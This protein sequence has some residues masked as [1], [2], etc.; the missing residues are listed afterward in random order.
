MKR[1]EFIVYG[2]DR[3]FEFM[4]QHGAQ[5]W[6]C[7]AQPRK[8]DGQR[9]APIAARFGMRYAFADSKVLDGFERLS[10]RL[11]CVGKHR[12][13]LQTRESPARQGSRVVLVDDLAATQIDP[14]RAW[15]S[16][17]LAI[18]ETSPENFQALLVASR[19]LSRDEHFRAARFLAARFDGDPGAAAVDQLHR[20]PG[21]PNFKSAALVN[22]KPFVCRLVGLFEAEE[23]FDLEATLNEAL[24]A[25]A[26]PAR[27]APR[28]RPA[29][30]NAPDADNSAAAFGWTLRQVQLGVRYEA[31]LTELRAS[32]L[33]HHDPH[34]WPARTLHNALHVLGMRSSR[35][36][37]LRDKRP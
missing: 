24:G 15:W 18:L 1:E 12:V 33:G 17:P 10:A 34:D 20:F 7:E 28:L 5:W 6:F 37:A 16:G 35:Y 23:G 11:E 13:D 26:C 31:I 14:V 21:A 25:C 2:A 27:P 4:G 3:F 32:W 29:S 22:G 9:G 19:P 8:K 30:A 36:D